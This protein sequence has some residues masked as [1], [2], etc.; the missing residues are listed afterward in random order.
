MGRHISA[1]TGGILA[2]AFDQL[3]ASI[4]HAGF[5]AFGLGVAKKQKAAHGHAMDFDVSAAT[6]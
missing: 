1:D 5:G 2:A 3:A 4:L 6:V